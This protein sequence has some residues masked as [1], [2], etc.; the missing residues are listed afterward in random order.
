MARRSGARPILSIPLTALAN[1]V[2]IKSL[3]AMAGLAYPLPADVLGDGD[4]FYPASCFPSFTPISLY[5]FNAGN[6]PATT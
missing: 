2:L 6:H 4:L 1:V 5:T 3:V